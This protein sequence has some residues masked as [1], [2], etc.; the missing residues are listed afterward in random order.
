MERMGMLVYGL[1]LLVGMQALSGAARAA[2]DDNIPGTALSNSA[3]SGTINN[4][5]NAS[6]DL[7]DVYHRTLSAG[8]ILI[9]TINGAA[10]TTFDLFLFPPGST[11]VNSDYDV[12]DTLKVDTGGYPY[13]VRY[14]VPPGAGGIYYLDVFTFAGSGTYSVTWQVITQ[15]DNQI[16]GVTAPA[17]PISGTLTQDTDIDDV[18]AIALLPTQ[19]LAASITGAAGTAFDLYLYSPSAIDVTLANDVVT[20]VAGDIYP[21]P[22]R[23]TV[24]AGQGGTYYLD[25]YAYSG[26]G[27]YTITYAIVPFSADDN[28]PGVALSPSPVTGTLTDTLDID[29]VYAVDLGRGDNLSLSL[30]GDAGTGFDLFLYGPDATD[31]LTDDWL[32]STADQNDYPKMLNFKAPQAG[33]YYV[34]VYE[35]LGTGAYTLTWSLNNAARNW[36]MY[37]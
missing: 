3:S 20:S 37:E 15:A 19:T 7:D 33:R 2:S 23:Y 22:L 25:A 8:D 16:P 27:S 28:V 24:P 6:T 9:A 31:V 18:Y 5:L 29:D 4:T 35:Y 21:A 36:Q 11:D 32:D 10:G 17:S 30:S 26:S 13:E 34:D 14:M 1:T 12:A